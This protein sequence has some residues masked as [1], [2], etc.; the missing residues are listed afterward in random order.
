MISFD[1]ELGGCNRARTYA[2]SILAA[3]PIGPEHG[4]IPRSLVFLFE[5]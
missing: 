3:I 1:D 4:L 2:R 5:L